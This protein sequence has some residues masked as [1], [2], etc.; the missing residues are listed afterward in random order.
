MSLTT[1]SDQDQSNLAADKTQASDRQKR[2]F[3]VELLAPIV[4]RR[5]KVIVAPNSATNEVQAMTEKLLRTRDKKPSS[6]SLAQYMQINSSTY[7]KDKPQQATH[8]NWNK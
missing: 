1:C 2:Q 5:T 7:K 3:E 4:D 8:T 6:I